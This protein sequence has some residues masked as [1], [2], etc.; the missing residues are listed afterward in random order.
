MKNSR[1][2]VI[3]ALFCLA[4]G[5]VSCSRAPSRGAMKQAIAECLQAQVPMSWAGSLMGGKNAHIES[6]DI[7]EVGSYQKGGQYWPVKARVKGTCQADFIFKTETVSFDR[8][9]DF[10]LSRD[11]YRH[12]KAEIELMQ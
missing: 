4:L 12:W 11:E 5:L 2:L 10:K 8:V 3:L 1:G 7:V 9:G 6:M